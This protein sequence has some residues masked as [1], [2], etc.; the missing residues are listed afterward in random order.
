MK[1]PFHQPSP[2]PACNSPKDQK[3]PYRT[4][5]PTPPRAGV[6]LLRKVSSLFRK[7]DSFSAPNTNQPSHPIAHPAFLPSPTA[8]FKT[9]R[10]IEKTER[11]GECDA[12]GPFPAT[13]HA[14]ETIGRRGPCDAY[15]AASNSR[16]A[17]PQAFET[18]QRYGAR[19]SGCVDDTCSHAFETSE[20]HRLR[21][22]GRQVP[23][24]DA[25]GL[26]DRCEGGEEGGRRSVWRHLFGRR[27]G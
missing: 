9:P 1:T 20:R 19:T 4:P 5:P 12:R 10:V 27:S 16:M 17:A 2:H 18:L 15:V 6:D 3:L 23:V 26:M 8:F 22:D 21:V 11:L 25:R 13:L 7:N 14:F 24:K